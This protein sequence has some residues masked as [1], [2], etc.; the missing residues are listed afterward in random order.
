MTWARSSNGRSRFGAG[1]WRIVTSGTPDAIRDDP[2][3]RTAYLGEGRDPLMLL[4]ESTQA[5]YGDSKVL[6]GMSLDVKSAVR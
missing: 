2:A 5:A 1:L 4:V 3:V 6:F